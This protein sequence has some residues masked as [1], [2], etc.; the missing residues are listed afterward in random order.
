MLVLAFDDVHPGQLLFQ[1]HG[2]Q[3]KG[4]PTG[5]GKTEGIVLDVYRSLKMGDQSRNSPA[6]TAAPASRPGSWRT[7]N[8]GVAFQ[9]FV[10]GAGQTSRLRLRRLRGICGNR[11]QRQPGFPPK[12][13][14]MPRPASP[15]SVY[16]LLGSICGKPEITRSPPQFLEDCA[17]QRLGMRRNKSVR[18]PPATAKADGPLDRSLDSPGLQQ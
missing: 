13:G 10:P 8:G 6:P 3:V 16:C 11:K 4:N 7:L 1:P 2:P 9:D 12:P 18:R 14:P 15:R 5:Q 17:A